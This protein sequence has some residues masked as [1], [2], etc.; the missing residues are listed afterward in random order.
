MGVLRRISRIS[1]E[2]A[3]VFLA[4]IL[5]ALGNSPGVYSVLDVA[6]SPHKFRLVQWELDNI[7]DKWWGLLAGALPWASR[8]DVEPKQL[9]EEFTALASELRMAETNLERLV[10][11]ADSAETVSMDALG[12]AQ[13]RVSALQ[14]EMEAMGPRVQAVLEEEIRSVLGQEGLASRWGTVFPPVDLVFTR[15]PLVLVVSPRDRIEREHSVLLDTRMKIGEMEDLEEV[16]LRQQD[17]SAL[18]VRAGGVA[19]Y[20]SM[21]DA[22]GGLYNVATTA[23]HEWLHHYWFFRPLG[24]NYFTN[25][26]MTTLNESAAD[27]AGD[28]MGAMVYENITGEPAPAEAHPEHEGEHDH[29]ETFDFFDEMRETRLEVDRLLEAEQVDEAEAY[30]EERRQVFVENG[31]LLRK[32]NQAYFA[33]H[34]SYGTNPASVSPIQGQ[35]EVV[36]AHSS[37]VGEFVNTMAQFGTYEQFEEYVEGLAPEGAFRRNES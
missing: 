30:M 29:P 8:D 26:T 10:A 6:T 20:P 2:L 35:V 12:L 33:F 11:A 27:L 3:L 31:Y 19:S 34:G 17:W 13:R 4:V 14:R 15:P 16:L 32:L 24:W 5:I 21:V 37:S 18:V 7:P 22:S 1:R 23:V 28:E 25:T 9:L 36:R